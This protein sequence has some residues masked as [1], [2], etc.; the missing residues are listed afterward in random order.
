MLMYTYTYT[1]VQRTAPEY[2]S[3][4]GPSV[5]DHSCPEAGAW[6]SSHGSPLHRASG[7]RSVPRCLRLCMKPALWA[8]LLEPLTLFLLRGGRP[9]SPSNSPI[10]PS[11]G[12]P[13][14]KG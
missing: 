13:L 3:I 8:D 2:L 4:P 14:S 12:Q 5:H 6:L 11:S 9:F 1:S 7:S 10:A